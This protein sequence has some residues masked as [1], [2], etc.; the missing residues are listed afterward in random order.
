MFNE[1]LQKG[2][3]DSLVN[4]DERVGELERKESITTGD[5]VGPY[6][7]EVNVS[8]DGRGDFTSVKAACDHIAAQDNLGDVEWIAWIHAGD[9]DEEPFDIPTF[10]TLEGLGGDVV[11]GSATEPLTTSLITSSGSGVTLRNL[12]IIA[13]VAPGASDVFLLDYTGD[14]LVL[15]GCR[16][17]AIVGASG[18]NLMG[19]V[20]YLGEGALDF[21][22][23]DFSISG[24]NGGVQY[25]LFLDVGANQTGNYIRSCRI[26]RATTVSTSVGISFAGDNAKLYLLE[27]SILPLDV[28]IFADTGATVFLRGTDYATGDGG[29]A[30]TYIYGE[31]GS[32][33]SVGLTAPDIFD[34][35]GSP[36]TT[37]GTIAVT[38]ADQAANTVFAG[39]ATGA[40]D[41]P[42]FRVLEVDDI[43]ELPGSKITGG[44]VIGTGA[45]HSVAVWND[46]DEIE[47][48]TGFAF[49]N[50][51]G[52]FSTL[53]LPAKLMVGGATDIVD[54]A[55]SG[56]GTIGELQIYTDE[57]TASGTA[58]AML[59]LVTDQ[60]EPTD[61][62]VGDIVFSNASLVSG[63]TDT[64]LGGMF[65]KTAGQTDRG[66]LTL[67][68]GSDGTFA[69][70]M[71]VTHTR[72]VLIGK[73]SGL[74]G[75]GDLDIDGN[76]NV[77][78]TY[79]GGGNLTITKALT[80]VLSVISTGAAANLTCTSETA[81]ANFNFNA[82]GQAQLNWQK[83]T[84]GAASARWLALMTSTAESGS[85]AGSNWQLLRR[86][87]A[88]GTLGNP[89][90]AAERA[91]GFVGVNLAE[92]AAAHQ[93][94]VNGDLRARLTDAVTNAVSVVTVIGH[95][96][97]GTAAANF[98]ARLLYQL[99]SSTTAAQDAVAVDAIWSTATN[100]SRTAY[101]SV[102]VVQAAAAL[103]EVARF[104]KSATAT[105][106][107]LHIWDADN[108]TLE[109]V[110]VGAA[111]SGGTGFKV[112]R[113]AN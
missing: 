28:D 91:T 106:T 101:L 96:T 11:I 13:S 10:T 89:V 5:G 58:R 105:H 14:N 99:E 62:A 7:W 109:R 22:G 34:V 71:R 30:I 12:Q 102:K 100:A 73:T 95:D 39:P 112:L 77:D 87:D 24:P 2:I 3:T 38:L 78:G 72:S 37:S 69:E 23:C 104:D 68:T 92:A 74:T 29:G 84:G 107:G 54:V 56:S 41:T 60:I 25:V 85:N 48:V 83:W 17:L 113:I 53:G 59:S 6:R 4:L 108:G 66:N 36:V 40:D 81:N 90:L 16:F 8:Q 20:R 57:Q 45:N 110:T 51:E 61:A 46:V 35:T 79:A 50:T 31:S 94:D 49:F 1:E 18:G 93:V 21:F 33:T 70:A 9:Y 32:V 52:T 44:V 111:D 15:D 97:T 86:T 80:A 98:G 47:D 19:C 26:W 64:R 27:T 76:I 63:A 75:A 55:G 65:V 88:G 42:H 67:W 82:A 43:P 103:A